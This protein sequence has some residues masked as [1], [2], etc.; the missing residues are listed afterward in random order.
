MPLQEDVYPPKD[1]NVPYI[2]KGYAI[3]L[4]SRTIGHIITGGDNKQK[5]YAVTVLV[6]GLPIPGPRRVVLRSVLVGSFPVDGLANF[7][8]SLEG[9]TLVFSTNAWPEMDCKYLVIF[10]GKITFCLKQ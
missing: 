6:Q 7:K 8:Y 5:L 1:F 3:W 10:Q 9:K 4:D 2:E